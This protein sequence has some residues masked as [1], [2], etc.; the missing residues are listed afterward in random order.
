MLRSRFF[1]NCTLRRDAI[2]ARTST[3]LYYNKC[4]VNIRCDIKTGANF[5]RATEGAFRL[6]RR[7]NPGTS[8]KSLNKY[9]PRTGQPALFACTGGGRAH[10]RGYIGL[11]TEIFGRLS[12]SSNL[13]HN[14][15]GLRIFFFFFFFP[16]PFPSSSVYTF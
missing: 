5:R 8:A 3:N 16:P 4:H 11:P 15:D 14:N 9:L 1:S 12:A 2:S 10:R 7:C 13:I 6:C